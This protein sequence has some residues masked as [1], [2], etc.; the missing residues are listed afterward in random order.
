MSIFGDETVPVQLILL[1]QETV[2]FKMVGYY[3]GLYTHKKTQLFLVHPELL[4]LCEIMLDGC[5]TMLGDL[6]I[7]PHFTHSESAQEYQIHSHLIAPL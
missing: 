2:T 4:Y 3:Y 7:R 1:N 6:I 5:S